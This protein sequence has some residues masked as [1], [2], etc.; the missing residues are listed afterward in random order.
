MSPEL[1]RYTQRI[2][3]RAIRLPDLTIGGKTAQQLEE[4]LGSA[5][6]NVGDNTRSLLRS[7]DFTTFPDQQTL[8]LVKVEVGDLGLTSNTPTTDQI[9][10]RASELGLDVCPAEVVPHLRLTYKDQPMDER[11]FVGMK[12]VT[13]SHGDPRVFTLERRDNGLWLSNTSAGPS[14]REP[15]EKFVFS[16]SEKLARQFKASGGKD[17]VQ[18]VSEGATDAKTRNLEISS[19]T[20]VIPE[21][22][23]RLPDI[24]IGG[25]TAQQL[26]QM[27]DLRINNRFLYRPDTYARSLLRSRDFTTFPDQQTLSLVK[28][29]VGD[30]DLTGH[31]TTDQ[32]YD[33]ANDLGLDLCPAEVGPHLRLAY[34]DQPMGEWLFVGM[35]QITSSRGLPEVFEL[36]RRDDG[37]CLESTWAH[38][39]NPRWNPKNEFV[40][41]LRK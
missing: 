16:L 20:P 8:S 3:E 41:S 35:K 4:E 9:Y 22:A 18:G 15:S 12:Q 33:K 17:I 28:V 37:L 10:A 25:K 14:H 29:K 24:T 40:F 34:K 1:D 39:N 21:G 11:L 36:F 30:L 38:P 19:V 32:V 13:D 27:L 31:P 26:E 6:I 2:L 23:I 5:G 7:Q